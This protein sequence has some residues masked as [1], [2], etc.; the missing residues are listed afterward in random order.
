MR[1]SDYIL[2]FIT[3]FWFRTRL[4]FLFLIYISFRTIFHFTGSLK[5]LEHGSHLPD[6]ISEA[7]HPLPEGKEDVPL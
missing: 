1:G 5:L 4:W 6:E 2:L 3:V 7:S